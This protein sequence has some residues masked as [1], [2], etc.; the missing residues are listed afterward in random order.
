VIVG[1]IMMMIWIIVFSGVN[2][3]KRNN[4]II[5]ADCR[6]GDQIRVISRDKSLKDQGYGAEGFITNDHFNGW[7]EVTITKDAYGGKVNIEGMVY[8][9]MEIKVRR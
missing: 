6:I 1:I 3:Q 2:T 9:Y 5:I 4:Q 8:E 7:Y